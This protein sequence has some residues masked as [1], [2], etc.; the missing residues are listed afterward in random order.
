MGRVE[1][2]AA[3]ANLGGQGTQVYA[4]LGNQRPALCAELYP[5]EIEELVADEV[6][7]TVTFAVRLRCLKGIE[8]AL[9]S[10]E[11]VCQRE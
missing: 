6:G 11:F 5:V 2:I 7:A 3:D 9:G 10:V 1:G 8:L 4:I